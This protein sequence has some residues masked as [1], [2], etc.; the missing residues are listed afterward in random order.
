M[1]ITRYLALLA[2]AVSLSAVPLAQASA[3][4]RVLDL[5]VRKESAIS[6]ELLAVDG[7][8]VERERISQNE[9]AYPRALVPEGEHLFK[10]AVSRAAHI[11]GD[12]KILV[13]F[14]AKVRAGASYFLTGTGENPTLVEVAKATA[15]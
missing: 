12:A 1:K 3:P 9:D 13:E 15:Q 6:L 2:A 8:Q 7:K 10:A 5:V 4:A 14:R 11:P